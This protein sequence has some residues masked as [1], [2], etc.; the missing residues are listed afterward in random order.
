MHDLYYVHPYNCKVLFS[1]LTLNGSRLGVA[2]LY[3]HPP[4]YGIN[5]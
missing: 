2:M 5:C 4:W 3:L 1:E